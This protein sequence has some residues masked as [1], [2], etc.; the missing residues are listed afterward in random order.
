MALALEG[1]IGRDIVLFFDDGRDKAS[2]KIGTLKAADESFL[3]IV[4]DGIEQAIPV[5]RVIRLE[6]STDGKVGRDNHV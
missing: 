3:V 4:C 6:P 1:L 2:R 5:N